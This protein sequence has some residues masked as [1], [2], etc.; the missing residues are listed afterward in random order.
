MASK[1][2]FIS[3]RYYSGIGNLDKRQHIEM[4]PG[5]EGGA[6][7]IVTKHGIKVVA[8]VHTADGLKDVDEELTP[9]QRKKLANHIKCTWLNHLYRG[10]AV[11]FPEEEGPGDERTDCH[12]PCGASQ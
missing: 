1:T 6:A 3:E 7:M 5:K 2:A 8:Y 12:G 9:E 11:F 4:N 10:K